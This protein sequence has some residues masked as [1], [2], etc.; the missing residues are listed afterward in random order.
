M[1]DN[2]LGSYQPLETRSRIDP[3]AS[4]KEEMSQAIISMIVKMYDDEGKRVKSN[5]TRL[6]E[7]VKERQKQMQLLNEVIGEIHRLTDGQTTLD[8]SQ[9]PA[10]LNKL[11]Q[12]R[13]CGAIIG[14][15]KTLDEIGRT[16]L[17][18]N[19]H[20]AANSWGNDN[21]QQMQEMDAHSRA[22]ERVL[23]MVRDVQ[24]SISQV[25]KGSMAGMKGG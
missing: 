14:T 5:I 18:D 13:E 24:K 6:A 20:L 16:R 11:D 9:N 22:Y 3:S 7:E 10:L 17:I 4:A 21:K 2:T 23:L 1:P 12:L 19:L 25:I 8:I 15:Q